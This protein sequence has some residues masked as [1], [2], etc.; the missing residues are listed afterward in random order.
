MRGRGALL[1]AAARTAEMKADK[2][3]MAR[4][5]LQAAEKDCKSWLSM[6]RNYV[7]AGMP[8]KARPYLKDL[9]AKYPETPFAEEARNLLAEIGE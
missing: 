7:K 1:A 9:L 4:I 2:E 3:L 6:A 8:D 5:R